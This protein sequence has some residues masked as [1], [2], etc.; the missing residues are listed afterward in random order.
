MSEF[1]L[2]SLEELKNLWNVV[3]WTKE[4]GTYSWLFR[5]LLT[6]C[7]LG[8]MLIVSLFH[9]WSRTKW[10]KIR[11][12]ILGQYLLYTA[13]VF[14]IGCTFVLVFHTV[15]L[16]SQGRL[17]LGTLTL[18]LAIVCYQVEYLTTLFTPS[19]LETTSL[20][21]STLRFILKI[22]L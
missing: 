12:L 11:F 9:H 6:T 16:M 18:L 15:K 14:G 22:V 19:P 5:S 3:T 10:W 21:W 13:G 20:G 17:L 7:C 4:L 1:A 8:V 2:L